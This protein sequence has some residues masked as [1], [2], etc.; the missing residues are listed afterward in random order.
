VNNRDLQTFQV[1][2]E[3]TGRLRTLIPAE[4]A[5]IAESGIKT[6]EDVRQMAAL[7]LDAMLVGETLVKSKDPMAMARELVGAAG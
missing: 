5:A 2:F 3:N 6:V 4:T 1:D 7:G